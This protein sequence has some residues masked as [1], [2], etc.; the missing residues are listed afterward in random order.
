MEGYGPLLC[1]FPPT[2]KIYWTETWGSFGG[3]LPLLGSSF[4]LLT[5]FLF[6]KFECTGLGDSGIVDVVCVGIS[7]GTLTQE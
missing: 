5:E 1:P 6:F 7:V 2:L 3:I 4:D